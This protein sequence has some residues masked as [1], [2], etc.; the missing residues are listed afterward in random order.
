MSYNILVS[1]ILQDRAS[2]HL[3]RW[4]QQFFAGSRQHSHQ[5]L[6]GFERL[7]HLKDHPHITEV[8]HIADVGGVVVGVKPKHRGPQKDSQ[9]SCCRSKLPQRD[10]TDSKSGG[11]RF[12]LL[13]YKS[14]QSE[15]LL[16]IHTSK[17]HTQPRSEATDTVIVGILL[18]LLQIHTSKLHTQPR[19]AAIDTVIVGIS[20]ALLQIHTSELHTQPQSEA[21]D[22]VIVGISLALARMSGLK[23]NA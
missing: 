19:S 13:T 8:T 16:Q 12:K 14:Q 11:N 9:N 1:R 6:K 2:T 15:R 23:Q 21:I 20:L 4:R 7:R 22:T 17:L 10:L 5:L 3:Q 18:A